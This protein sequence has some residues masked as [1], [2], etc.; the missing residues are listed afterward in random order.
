MPSP[1]RVLSV[2]PTPSGVRSPRH[3]RRVRSNIHLDNVGTLTTGTGNGTNNLANSHLPSGAVT[4]DGLGGKIRT[5]TSSHH[6]R[7]S[8]PTGSLTDVSWLIHTALHLTDS[9]RES[10][11]QSWLSK[12]ESS[13]SLHSPGI[14]S[15]A[16][17][18][19]ANQSEYF[20][21]RSGRPSARN[22]PAGSRRASRSHGN[23]AGRRELRMTSIPGAGPVLGIKDLASPPISAAAAKLATAISSSSSH[24]HPR[25]PSTRSSTTSIHPAWTDPATQA[26]AQASDPDL[27]SYTTTAIYD[28]DEDAS[29]SENDLLSTTSSESGYSSDEREIQQSLKLG[30]GFI[31][32][33]WVDNAI[34]TLLMFEDPTS[35]STSADTDDD[36]DDA[37]TATTR[38]TFSKNNKNNSTAPKNSSS[39]TGTSTPTSKPTVAFSPD[40]KDILSDLE[41]APADPKSRWEDVK[42]IGRLIWGT[43]IL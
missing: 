17:V 1:G 31:F 36:D 21:S 18:S 37:S 13:T 20:S 3:H 16:T 14:L 28:S 43:P 24:P 19:T 33:R 41:T 4:S 6:K 27:T 29:D 9:S 10:K 34:D 22:T 11:G 42:Y 32:G 23:G 8:Q 5:S 40:T 12:R 26:E 38:T 30:R 7:L 35:T 39:S 25:Q 2:P 15:P